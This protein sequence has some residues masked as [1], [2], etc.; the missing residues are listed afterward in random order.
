MIISH[1]LAFLEYIYRKEV[2]LTEELAF[3][4]LQVSSEYSLPELN[5]ISGEYLINRLTIENFVRIAQAVD[6][7]GIIDLRP[8]IL[9]FMSRNLVP[10]RER[11]DLSCLPVSILIEVL[12]LLQPKEIDSNFI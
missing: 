7:F 11:E 12:D 10:L 4:L 1:I 2:N 9:K 3:E 8:H 6:K 5:K